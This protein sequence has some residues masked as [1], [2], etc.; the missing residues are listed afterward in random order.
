[1]SDQIRTTAERAAHLRELG[2]KLLFEVTQRGDRFDLVR[3]IDVSRPV[4]HDDL[5]LDQAEELL[6]TWKLRGPHGG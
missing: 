5:T 2:P 4:R 3:T 1:M 6:N